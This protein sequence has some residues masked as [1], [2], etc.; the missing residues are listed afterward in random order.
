VRYALQAVQGVAEVAAVGGFTKQYQINVDP[1]LLLAYDVPLTQVIDAV[2]KGNNEVGG[3]LLEFAG[4]EYMVRGR[5]YIT[6]VAD[7]ERIAVGTDAK[8]GTPILVKNVAHVGIGPDLRRGVADLDGLGDAVGG[9][10]VMRHGENA[11]AVID[12]VKAKLDELAPT[13]PAGVEIVTTYDRSGLIRRSIDTLVHS[14]SEEMI[15]VSAVILLFLWHIPS[16]IVPIVT[17]PVSVFLA[18][19]PL[20][21]M[22]L[23]SNIMSLAGIAISIGV[24][25]DGAIVE[26]E[27]AYKRLEQWI[28]GG[29]GDFHAAP[30][31]AQGSR[32]LG[33]L[34][35]AGDRRRLPAIFTLVD[36]EGRLFKPLA[37]S[38]NLTMRWRRSRRHARPGDAALHRM[39]RFTFR[40]R[41]L[42]WLVNAQSWHVLS[43]GATPIS[44]ILFRLYEPA[45]RWVLRHRIT[46]LVIAVALVA[47]TIPPTSSS[48]QSSC[49]RSTRAPSCTCPLPCP[50]CRSL[51]HSAFC[52]SKIGFCARSPKWIASS[53]R[54]GALIRPPI[55]PHSRWW[56]P[57]CCSSRSRNGARSSA[58]IRTG[59]SPCR[60]CSPVSRPTASPS[61]SCRTKWM[62]SC[63]SPASPT[64]GPCR[65]R[66]ASTCC[67]PAFARRSASRF[68]DPT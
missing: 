5:G 1:Q 51:K 17:I 55:P 42:A 37:Y 62:R 43:R 63:A 15:I 28:A 53:A 19:I 59:R 29:R 7:I 13:L 39:H 36:Q 56:R 34:L 27:N 38:K 6:S 14:L 45:C 12:R 25:V 8:S 61:R 21:F 50:A 9:V 33:L 52:R 64:S 67:R 58:G 60:R 47:T 32:A 30:A 54:P 24:L 66:T 48:A 2:R 11:L 68:W 65:S 31:G 49:R 16:A 41:P 10:V 26:V 20:Y 22:G 35:A 23:T 18:F 57:P 40:P 4:T 46:T 44:R 3:R